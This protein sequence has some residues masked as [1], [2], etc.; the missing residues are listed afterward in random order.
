[1]S[2]FELFPV[3][4]KF[5]IDRHDVL[6]K[7]HNLT[8][9]PNYSLVSKSLSSIN[10]ANFD[11]KDMQNV[12][13]ICSQVVENL[14]NEILVTPELNEYIQQIFNLLKEFGMTTQCDEIEKND[15]LKTTPLTG[16][17]QVTI[18]CDVCGQR[19]IVGKVYH[20]KT[21][22][23]FDSCESCLLKSA[24]SSDTADVPNAHSSLHEMELLNLKSTSDL[25]SFNEK[26]VVDIKQEWMDNNK[27]R[28]LNDE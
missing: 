20:C 19:P 14:K 12:H 10:L 3:A 5:C 21:C 7:L 1:M 23:D 26:K 16:V 15:E 11:V 17:A 13:S 28:K 25:I 27:K 6:V 9:N 8:Q 18:G 4:L 22:P 24:T 2:F